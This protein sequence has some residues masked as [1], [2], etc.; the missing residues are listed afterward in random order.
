MPF[1]LVNRQ[2]TL[3]MLL[4]SELC[5]VPKPVEGILFVT[6]TS[7][8]TDIFLSQRCKGT[9]RY[10]NF[11]LPNSSEGTSVPRQA[12]KRVAR[13]PCKKVH[14]KNQSAESATESYLISLSYLRCYFESQ[15]FRISKPQKNF[16]V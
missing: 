5:S 8:V 16:E 9:Q 3:G 7:S 6:S 4:G 15:K 13:N 14:K 1:I 12:V 10:F 2:R 11:Q